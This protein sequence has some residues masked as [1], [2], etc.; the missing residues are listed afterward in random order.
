MNTP[1][2]RFAPILLLLCACDLP[3]ED[4]GEMRDDDDA[5]TGDEEME[6]TGSDPTDPDPTD[7]DPTGTVDGDALP[8]SVFLFIHADD[9]YADS[10]RAYDIATD[11]SWVV[12]DFGGGVEARSVAI[13][14]DRKTL[15]ISSYYE[16]VNAEESEGIWRVPA[17]G[18]E[19]E[20]IMEP[21]SGNGEGQSVAELVYSPDG[22]HVYFGYSDSNGGSTLARVAAEGGVPE[23]FLDSSGTCSSHVAPAPAPNGVQLVSVRADCNDPAQSG[24]V[25]HDMP[26]TTAGQVLLAEGVSYGFP[27]AAPQWTAD[28]SALLFLV[29][30][31]FDI[32][33]DGV[34]DGQG[35]S[36]VL[37]DT[38]SGN[39]VD[40]VPPADGQQIYSIA[41]SPTETHIVMCMRSDAGEDL[42]LVDLTGEALTY[43]A[44]TSDG[45]SC[46]AAW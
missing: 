44:L 23:L 34:F 37:M 15:A 10:V 24:L 21:W 29:D 39:L 11:E 19:P 31:K 17:A 42:W 25:L 45:S 26:P 8:E 41:L 13:H 46:R 38:A 36:V 9:A 28:A 27:S 1:Y 4:D 40:L 14:P 32:E 20:L 43:R 2:L 7:P 16:S 12:T 22:A 6:E 33:G 18:G 3:S 5:E 35:T 30:G